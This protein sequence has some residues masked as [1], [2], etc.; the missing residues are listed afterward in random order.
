VRALPPA[1]R[2][3]TAIAADAVSVMAG[4]ALAFGG[5]RV[6]AAIGGHSPALGLPEWLRFALAGAGG[7]L[8]LA[9]LAL[10]RL[11]EGKGAALAAAFALGAALHLAASHAVLS[12]SLPPSVALGLA[13]AAGLAVAAPLPH[14]FLAAAHL[15][16][17]FASPLALEAV[18]TSTA[19]G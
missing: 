13:A 15:A 3:A 6:A 4:L 18:V 11:E 2:K 19:A 16:G 1:A 10:H 5:A 17:L 12:S 9:T 14:A 7:A 8:L